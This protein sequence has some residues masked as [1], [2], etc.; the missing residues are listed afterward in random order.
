MAFNTALSS[1]VLEEKRPFR[2]SVEPI[3]AGLATL[4]W[5]ALRSAI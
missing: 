3:S 5:I 2:R 4:V 1:R